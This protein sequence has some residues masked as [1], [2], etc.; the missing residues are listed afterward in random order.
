MGFISD[1]KKALGIGSNDRAGQINDATDNA[2]DGVEAEDATI[3]NP[4]GRKKK[5]KGIGA[6]QLRPRPAAAPSL[7][8][9]IPTT[10][11]G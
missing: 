3:G 9:R 6:G 11:R 8:S 2:V 10:L 7:S 5:K 1:V 4:T